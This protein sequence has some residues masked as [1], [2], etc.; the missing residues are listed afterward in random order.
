MLQAPVLEL[1]HDPIP[2]PAPPTSSW[3][4]HAIDGSVWFT[5]SD[6]DA[7]GLITQQGQVT[8]YP[9]PTHSDNVDPSGN[10]TGSLPDGIVLGA[11]GNM[12]FVEDAQPT[13]RIGTITPAGGITEYEVSGAD[14]DVLGPSL[15]VGAD[16]N[17]WFS[18]WSE[19]VGYITAS[20]ETTLSTTPTADP[21]PSS[22]L[23][24][25]DGRM[26]FTE[27]SDL[28]A[29]GK[30]GAISLTAVAPPNDDFESASSLTGASGFLC[31][32]D[33]SATAE[34]GEPSTDGIPP[35]K[36]LWWSWTAPATGTLV[37]ST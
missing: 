12:W 16:C 26:W 25:P 5:S 32:N 17:M 19:D 30:V 35:Q 24:G 22:M 7:V 18:V 20:G 15:A 36:T 6:G 21:W 2:L 4:Y 1:E 28:A 9:L 34:T 33:I 29:A 14:G 13:L 8:V 23:A 10:P 11:D 37:V 27:P 3:S 31:S